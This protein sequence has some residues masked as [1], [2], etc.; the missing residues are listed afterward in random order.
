V[1]QQSKTLELY[2]PI[3]GNSRSI[4]ISYYKRIISKTKSN[5]AICKQCAHQI[6]K[7]YIEYI[8]NQELNSTTLSVGN[9]VVKP[10]S[11]MRRDERCINCG[12]YLDCLDTISKLN[13][14]NWAII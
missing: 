10:I 11:I 1:N 8:K 5:N 3:C 14:P 9:C 13:W 6:H 4:S 12:L 7:P 2:C